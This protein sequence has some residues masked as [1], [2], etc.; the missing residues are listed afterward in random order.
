MKHFKLIAFLL[1]ALIATSCT[2]IG[3]GYVGLEYSLAGGDKGKA[4]VQ[5]VYG[6]EMYFPPT[7][8]IVKINTRN[9]HFEMQ[10]PITVQAKGG[11]NVIVHPAFNYRINAGTVDSLYLVWGVTDDEQIQGKLLEASL[12]TNMREVTNG[13]SI[14][15]LL[16]NRTIYDHA[17][18]LAMNQKLAPYASLF[19]FTSGVTPDSSMAASIANKSASIQRAL[20][21]EA[22]E[23]EQHAL[24]SLEVIKAQRD[25]SV[26][27]INAQGEAR[28]IREKQSALTAEYVEYIK[29][30]RW[31]GKLPSTQLG[32]MSPLINLGK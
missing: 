3:P 10:Q 23:R 6:W 11:T 18:E 32:S 17:L 29:W 13:W 15:S 19:Q 22:Q 1:L 14:D 2:K 31:D 30:S 4:N 28:A 16:N 9:Q 7:T 20:A 21:A 5:P 24:A 27:V 25:S 26:K 12:L 8:G